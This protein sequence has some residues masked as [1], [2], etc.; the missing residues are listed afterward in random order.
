MSSES[1]I[2]VLKMAHCLVIVWRCFEK[3]EMG[4]TLLHS[5]MTSQNIHTNVLFSTGNKISIT[6]ARVLLAPRL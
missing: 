5:S 4:L 2:L 6:N 1:D 3:M